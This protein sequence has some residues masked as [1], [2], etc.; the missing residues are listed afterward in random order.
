MPATGI[1]PAQVLGIS[2][3]K[4]A[5]RHAVRSIEERRKGARGELAI[6][7]SL[8]SVAPGLEYQAEYLGAK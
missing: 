7:D 8:D 1:V 5:K 3:E 6:L 2:A 4:P